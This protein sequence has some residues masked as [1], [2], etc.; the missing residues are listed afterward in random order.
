MDCEDNG[1]RQTEEETGN[2]RETGF[3]LKKET[4]GRD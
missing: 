3:I 2:G 1:E 4:V